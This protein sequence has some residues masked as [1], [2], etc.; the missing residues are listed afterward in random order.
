MARN[1]VRI[2]IVTIVGGIAMAIGEPFV[3]ETYKF[4]FFVVSGA[5]L[6]AVAVVV[7]RSAPNSS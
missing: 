2:A 5:L 7:L 6:G 3:D 1:A 4:A